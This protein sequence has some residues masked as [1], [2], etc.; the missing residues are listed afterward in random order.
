MKLTDQEM[1]RSLGIWLL[2]FGVTSDTK[3][4]LLDIIAK[5]INEVRM[6][7]EDSARIV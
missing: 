3:G 6:H 1:L 7:R 5:S 2:G 4:L